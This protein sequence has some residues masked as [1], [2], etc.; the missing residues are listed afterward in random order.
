MR[1]FT[2]LQ[3]AIKPPALRVGANFPLPLPLRDCAT[4]NKVRSS[5]RENFTRGFYA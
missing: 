4:L 2:P 1:F 5:M 3:G